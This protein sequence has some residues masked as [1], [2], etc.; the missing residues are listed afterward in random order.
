[1]ETRII[2]MGQ[3]DLI[4]PTGDGVREAQNRVVM[5]AYQTDRNAP[6]AAR[7]EMAPKQDAFGCGTSRNPFPPIG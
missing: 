4:L 2:P 7:P 1:V 6:S 5:V 3:T